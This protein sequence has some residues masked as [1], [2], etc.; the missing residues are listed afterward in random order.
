MVR[1]KICSKTSN[2]FSL[3]GREK[4]M[5][6]DCGKKLFPNRMDLI[7][8]KTRV[9]IIH[10]SKKIKGIIKKIHSKQIW[11]YDGLMVELMTGEAGNLIK[12][13]SDGAPKQVQKEKRTVNEYEKENLWFGKGQAK[14]IRKVSKHFSLDESKNNLPLDESKNDLSNF[15]QSLDTLSKL[16]IQD[17]WGSVEKFFTLAT[18]KNEINPVWLVLRYELLRNFLN[19]TLSKEEFFDKN[20]ISQKDVEYYFQTWHKFLEL[21]GIDPWHQIRKKQKPVV[22]KNIHKYLTNDDLELFQSEINNKTPLESIQF[23]ENFIRQ[24]I[25]DDSYLINLFNNTTSMLALLNSQQLDDL[26]AELEN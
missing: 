9:E 21:M 16:E 8:G 2:S 5:C 20:E 22:I 1:C 18:T 25:S 23:M 13:I 3:K 19:R 17:N 26:Q 4:Q 24:K 7:L 10:N 15:I 6:T 12:I 14:I 11:D